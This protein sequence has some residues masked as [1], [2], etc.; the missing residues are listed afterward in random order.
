M[1]LILETVDDST[2]EDIEACLS[3]R[4]MWVRLEATKGH[5]DSWHGMNAMYE[6]TTSRKAPEESMQ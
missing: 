3:A 5:C 6:F 2:L 1:G 4:A